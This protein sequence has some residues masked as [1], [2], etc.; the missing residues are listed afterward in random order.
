MLENSENYNISQIVDGLD[1]LSKPCVEYEIDRAI[2]SYIKEQNIEE[3]PFQWMA[4][5]MAFAFMENYPDQETGWGTYYGPMM[6]LPNEAGQLSESPSIRLVTPEILAYWEKR[7]KE[8]KHPI[9]KLRYA[10]LVWDFSKT[11][12]NTAPH[13][14]IA[15][16]IIDSTI[17]IAKGKVHKN[18]TDV[19]TKLERA[20]SVAISINDQKRKDLLRD[21]II[22]YE[23]E[24]AQDDKP[25]LWGFSFNLLLRNKKIPLSAEVENKLVQD[26]EN[27]LKRLSDVNDKEKLNPWGGAESAALDLAAYYRSINK[28]EDIKRVLLTLGNVFEIASEDA[29]PLQISAWL[30]HIH[31]IYLEFGLNDEAQNIAKKIKSVGP[32]IKDEMKTFSYEMKITKKEMDDYVNAL[33][34]EDLQASIGRIANQFVPLKDQVENQLRDLKKKAPVSFLFTKQIQD[35]HGRPIA[36]IGPIEDDLMGHIV[37]QTSQNMRISSIFLGRVLEEL[38]SRFKI[39]TQ[40]FVDYLYKSP[41][42][43]EDKKIILLDGIKAYLDGNHLVAIHLLVPQIENAFRKLVELSGGSVL[44]PGR[45]GGMNL[46]T[47]DE[48][49][50]DHNIAVIFGEDESLYFRI[51]LTDQRGWN[52]R[53]NVCHGIIP[54]DTFQ[55][56]ISDR[57]FHVLL[58]LSLI[59]KT[60]KK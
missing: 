2:H 38:I 48:I 4:E 44:K 49:L 58:L 8:A 19:I 59:R 9:L 24:I 54:A 53:N 5:G 18:E 23:D 13:F 17:E 3:L 52:I 20:L 28:N 57:I 34:D 60:E 22:Q 43:E 27:R 6:V 36:T 29:T 47:L 32:K 56:I 15:H 42:F 26:L 45:T 41:V 21:T 1:L 35:H 46:K 51:L 7:S 50:R 30:Q 14:S 39:T 40:Y 55:S 16:T 25:G 10:D 12:A 33:I 37:S 31:A 11:N